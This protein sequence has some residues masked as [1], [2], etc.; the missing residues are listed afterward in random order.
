MNAH[1]PDIVYDCPCCGQ[2]GL[3][4][5]R[6]MT[7]PPV[8]AVVC[9][10]CDRIWRSPRRVG[11]HNDEQLDGVCEELGIEP[12]WTNL[13]SEGQGVPWERIDEEYRAFSAGD[14]MPN[15]TDAGNGSNGICRVID[16][17]RSP[18]PDPGRSPNQR[19]PPP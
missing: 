2:G 3:E 19:R 7:S 8:E 14:K 12:Q 9:A 10:E 13:E 18:S 6:I 15:K 11:I 17:S 1:I 5:V 16:A 4:L